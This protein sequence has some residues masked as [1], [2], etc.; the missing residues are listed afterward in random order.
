MAE[1]KRY[2]IEES[3]P[4]LLQANC[5]RMGSHSNSDDH[6]LY[7]SE[8]ERNYV[9]EYDPLAKFRRL[10]IR[11]E[12]FTEEELQAIE[13]D[14]KAE[15][16]ASHKAAMAAPDPDPESIYDHVFSERNNFV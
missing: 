12:R 14:T 11:Y 3:K 2:A 13:E 15:I 9:V 4:V 8:A 10:L 5:V 6:L 16:K 7:R 1:A